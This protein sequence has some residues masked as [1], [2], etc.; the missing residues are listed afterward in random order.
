MPA[1]IHASRAGEGG[2]AAGLPANRVTGGDGFLWLLRPRG[3]GQDLQI[4]GGQDWG[5]AT[6]AE[7]EGDTGERCS[8]FDA[9]MGL[10]TI[11]NDDEA[12]IAAGWF[13]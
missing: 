4:E 11:T 2:R 7:D 9:E 1:A 10:S 8:D 13:R 6:G 12:K 3:V 5:F